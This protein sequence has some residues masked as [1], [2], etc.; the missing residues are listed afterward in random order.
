[1]DFN[2][3]RQLHTPP[4]VLFS[5]HPPCF[6]IF[7]KENHSPSTNESSHRTARSA[8]GSCNQIRISVSRTYKTRVHHVK[9]DK[10][11]QLASIRQV[12]VLRPANCVELDSKGVKTVGNLHGVAAPLNSGGRRAPV[13]A[14]I[15]R[16]GVVKLPWKPLQPG[17]WD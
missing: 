12:E 13:S 6:D 4:Y 7:Q 11:V 3:G 10:D 2:S 5:M 14:R 16:F 1:M 8:G 9:R 15:G 17:S